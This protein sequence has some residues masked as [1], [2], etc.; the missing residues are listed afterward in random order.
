MSLHGTTGN[1]VSK[2][3]TPQGSATAHTVVLLWATA[4]PTTGSLAP[5]AVSTTLCS[6]F[7]WWSER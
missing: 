4:Y 3:A 7:L 1:G 5:C 2:P 6:S